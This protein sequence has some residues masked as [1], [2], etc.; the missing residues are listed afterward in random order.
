M[1]YQDPMT[2]LNP[3]MRIGSQVTEGLRAHGWS[4]DAARD[5]AIEVLDEVGLPRPGEADARSTR[6]SSPAACGNAC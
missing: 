1:V 2:S 3:V 5:R 4:K 6:T